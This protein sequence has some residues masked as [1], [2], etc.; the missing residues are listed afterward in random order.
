MT[1][2]FIEAAPE[3]SQQVINNSAWWMDKEWIAVMIAAASA[4]I[5]FFSLG[6]AVYTK[7]LVYHFQRPIIDLDSSEVKVET[8]NIDNRVTYK[9]NW[10]LKL[11]NKGKHPA[12]DLKFKA[13]IV[14]PIVTEPLTTEFTS[15]NKRHPE[16]IYSVYGHLD[17]DGVFT[18]ENPA[19]M[20][21]DLEY[22][23]AFKPKKVFTERRYYKL[24][25]EQFVNDASIEEKNEIEKIIKKI[26]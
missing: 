20:I 3:I 1:E 19:L 10:V 24:T 21:L 5:S 25:G 13:T 12:L 9:H 23:D 22:K 26:K 4:L 7:R 17:A 11:K 6:F 15:P 14:K 18:K 8:K 2:T 16:D